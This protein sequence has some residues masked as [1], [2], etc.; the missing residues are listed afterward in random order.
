[1]RNF[2]LML[3]MAAAMVLAAPTPITS[4]NTR[5]ADQ[6]EVRDQAKVEKQPRFELPRDVLETTS[7][8]GQAS[9]VCS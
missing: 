4:G 9:T 7:T 5:S 2:V 3:S 6:V 1:M 8:S